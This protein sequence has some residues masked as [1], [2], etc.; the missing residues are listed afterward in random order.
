MLCFTV[1]AVRATGYALPDDPVCRSDCTS[2]VNPPVYSATWGR[3][4]TPASSGDT[5]AEP[6]LRFTATY[7]LYVHIIA[8]SNF[9]VTV[10]GQAAHPSD[11]TLLSDPSTPATE[12][13]ISVA[14]AS[15]TVCCWQHGS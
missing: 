3:D 5:I 7:S 9:R 4:D 8:V 12:L 14:L 6:V 13:V 10:N 11:V 15:S 1:A 2:H